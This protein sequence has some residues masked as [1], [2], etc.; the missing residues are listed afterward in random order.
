MAVFD[1]GGRNVGADVVQYNTPDSSEYGSYNPYGSDKQA[2][3][4]ENYQYTLRKSRDD[5]QMQR[6]AQ[7]R[8]DVNAPKM[9]NYAVDELGKTID[10]YNKKIGQNNN[11]R[12]FLNSAMEGEKKANEF[13]T[14][15]IDQNAYNLMRD[16]AEG[17]APS[18]AQL[19]LQTE[20]GNLENVARR[21]GNQMFNQNQSMVNSARTYNPGMARA[22]M[23]Q[24]ASQQSD[25]GGR[26]LEGQ[27]NLAGQYAAMRA[28]EMAAARGAYGQYALGQQQQNDAQANALRGM[29]LNYQQLR[30]QGA[31]LQA[32]AARDQ[33]AL[34][35]QTRLGY[36]EQRMKRDIA[37]QQADSS[38][39]DTLI[40]W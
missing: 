19:M 26:T 10:E 33:A 5:L 17:K 29:N 14:R 15:Q 4:L 25:L 32:S 7:L 8:G 9:N 12:A 2:Q 21:Q 37:D 23:F 35:N 34:Y 40:P 3:E 13:Q 36:E 24:N 18:Q 16:A 38:L 39:I 28:Q 6:D 20:S 31:A 22:A 1:V 27:Q 30:Q 11:Q